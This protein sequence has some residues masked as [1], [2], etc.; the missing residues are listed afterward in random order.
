MRV[1][2]GTTAGLPLCL[3]L[4]FAA[5]C[6]SS[7]KKLLEAG[8][9]DMATDEVIAGWAWD[10]RKPDQAVN[11]EIYVDTRLLATVSADQFR[12]D[13]QEAGVGDGKHGFAYPTPARLKDGRPHV[14]RVKIAGTGYELQHSPKT[15]TFKPPRGS[16]P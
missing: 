12:E 6:R 9:F 5:G 8:H 4:L 15:V 7:E 2:L 11:V 10:Q 16:N 3:T 1:Q 13:L 14:I